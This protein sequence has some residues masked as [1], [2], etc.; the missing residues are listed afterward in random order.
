MKTTD[1]QKG[2]AHLGLILLVVVALLAL[3]GWYVWKQTSKKDNASGSTSQSTDKSSSDEKKTEKKKA[4]TTSDWVTYSNAEGAFSFKHP[5]KWVFAANPE[6]C[7]DG[8]V[9]FA[10]T[11]DTLGKCAT[12]FGGQ[13]Q[14]SSAD[15]DVRDVYKFKEPYYKDVTDESVTVQDVEG[16]KYSTTVMGMEDEVVIGSMPDNTRLVRYVFFVN[17]KTYIASYVQ[18]PEYPDV[19][20]D[21]NLL[22]T[23]TFKFSAE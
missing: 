9:L 18:E 19:L 6:N 5:S 3:G 23:K 14:V 15:G 13:M 8:L 16:N 21:F 10:P 1:S 17:E 4:D 20:S 22:V 12:E 2:I 11:T 7:S